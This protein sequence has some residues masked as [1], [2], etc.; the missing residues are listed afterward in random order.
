[1]DKQ[2]CV[3][4]DLLPL[5][6][7]NMVSEGTKSFV[8]EH[9]NGCEECRTKLEQMQAPAELVPDTD[10]A[11][12]KNL[13]KKLLMKRIQTIVFTAA[14]VFAVV[15]SVFS[16]L[17]SPGYFPYS[18]NLLNVM[19]DPNGTIRIS[20]D[21][22][23]TGYSSIKE[24][25][26]ETGTEVYRISAWNTI[27]DMYFSDR[28]KQNMV[29]LPNAETDTQI[30]YTQNNGSEDVL[31][32]G[33]ANADEGVTTLPRLILMPYFLLALFALAV[34]IILRFLMR[35]R[36]NVTI[37]IDRVI[38][39]PVSYMLAHLCTKMV[40]FKTYSSQRDFFIIIL[41]A[42]LIYCAIL[43]GVS[44]YKSRTKRKE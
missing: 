43:T 36:N 15:I 4:K 29:I 34:L 39:L 22:K 24:S 2:C 33:S 40:S 1:M 44:L 13:K 10:P 17:T 31:I 37:W 23:V 30:Y 19:E 18:N 21:D 14:L 28:G 7:E 9:L 8:E 16:I 42:V 3:I 25:D 38:P 35:N 20:F 6:M 41:V 12:L 5:Y 32:Y 11:P 27:W 26:N